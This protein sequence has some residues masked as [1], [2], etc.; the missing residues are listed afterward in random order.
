MR[1]RVE[2]DEDGL[3]SFLGL[4]HEFDGEIANLVVH[5]FHP[6]RIERAASSIFCLPIL[7]QRGNLC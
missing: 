4:F 5:R 2:P 7:P 6:F 1:R 3:P